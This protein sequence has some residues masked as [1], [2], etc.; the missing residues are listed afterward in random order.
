VN[1]SKILRTVPEFRPEWDARR[2][3]KELFETYQRVGLA[4]A[5]FEGPRFKRID[6]I[7]ML[8]SSGALDESLRWRAAGA[9]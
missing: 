6:H 4:L 2:G 8:I 9:N 7:R 3:A 5:D 1:C